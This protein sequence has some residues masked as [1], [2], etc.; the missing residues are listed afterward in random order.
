MRRRL[1]LALGATLSCALLVITAPTATADLRP[2]KGSGKE[3]CPATYLCLYRKTA[4]NTNAQFKV[5]VATTQSIV[6]VSALSIKYVNSLYNRTPSTVRACPGPRY[7][8][9]CKDVKPNDDLDFHDKWKGEP[10][11][12]PQSFEIP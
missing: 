10:N 2:I 4:F 3:S 6:D 12:S 8:G 1:T 7:T 9:T 11:E 5:A